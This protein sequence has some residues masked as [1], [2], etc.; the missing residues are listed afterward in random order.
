M[1]TVKHAH[2]SKLKNSKISIFINNLMAETNPCSVPPVMSTVITNLAQLRTMPRVAAT[3]SGTVPRSLF[4]DG[5]RATFLA[6]PVDD[7][8]NPTADALLIGWNRATLAVVAVR[9]KKGTLL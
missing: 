7:G 6:S 5:L 2:I 1:T 8:G 3:C 9:L 4:A